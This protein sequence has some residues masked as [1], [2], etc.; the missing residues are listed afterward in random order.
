MLLRNLLAADHNDSYPNKGKS[1][2]KSDYPVVARVFRCSA[3]KLGLVAM[4]G[5]RTAY[6]V[7]NCK[8]ETRQRKNLQGSQKQVLLKIIAQ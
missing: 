6:K 7:A 2:L 8:R 1:G 3:G 5:M 4:S